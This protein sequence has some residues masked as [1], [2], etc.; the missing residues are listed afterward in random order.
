MPRHPHHVWARA[1]PWIDRLV[2]LIDRLL[3]RPPRRP[4]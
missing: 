2:A 4:R 3:H 1:R